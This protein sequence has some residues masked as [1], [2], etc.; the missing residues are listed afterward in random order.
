[1]WCSFSPRYH[2]LMT[3]CSGKSEIVWWTSVTV[4]FFFWFCWGNYSF[5]NEALVRIILFWFWTLIFTLFVCECTARVGFLKPSPDLKDVSVCNLWY[6]CMPDCSGTW[7][8]EGSALRWLV[9][10]VLEVDQVYFQSACWHC[11]QDLFMDLRWWCLLES[12]SVVD[13]DGHTPRVDWTMCSTRF[14]CW[15][16]PRT[17]H[18][19]WMT[20]HTQMVLFTNSGRK[21][22]NG[23]MVVE[24]L[25][26]FRSIPKWDILPSEGHFGVK[27]IMATVLKCYS[28]P[29]CLK[30]ATSTTTDGKVESYTLRK[31]TFVRTTYW[32]WAETT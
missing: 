31:M 32:N 14:I 15:F 26:D 25:S 23:C 24:S 12:A 1:M 9:L 6:I 5:T 13:P 21:F 20:T 18:K 29:K 10:D 7:M 30:L 11:H 22:I 3:S 16:G 28:K 19:G 27:T 17:A 8:K 2:R 4:T